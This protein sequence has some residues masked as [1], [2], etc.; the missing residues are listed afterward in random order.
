MRMTPDIAISNETA[1]IKK[2]QSTDVVVV[3][4]RC[5]GAATAM[6]LARA[7]HDVVV[8]DRATFPSDTLSTHA[9]AR[10]GVV[11]LL[12][13][14][15]LDAV[16]SSGAPEIRRVEFH[17]RAG[18][19]VRTVKDRYGT[20]FLVAPR[21]HAGELEL[22][23]LEVRDRLAELLPFLCVPYGMFE[24]AGRQAEHL[25]ADA[26]ASFVECLDRDLVTLAGF[27]EHVFLRH[28]AVFEDQFHG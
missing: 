24:R 23:A 21:R 3:G 6:L 9:I 1:A 27:A 12:R 4:A 2:S 19:V 13:W 11:Q 26:D 17:T 28:F 14:G 20:D 18:S 10:G 15:L 8:A 25:R 22:D 7:G 16:V 5:A